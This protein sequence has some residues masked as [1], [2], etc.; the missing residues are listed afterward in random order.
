LENRTLLR[1][2]VM[3]DLKAR[4]VGS[5]M[6]FFWSVIFPLINLCVFTFVFRI[7]LKTRWSDEQG[8]LEVAL[9][10]L[11]GIIVWTAFAE[12]V[13]RCT[14]CLVDNA[15]LL[16]KVVFPA[17]VF[18]AYI[19]T[20]AI[21]NMCIGLPIVLGAVVWFGY[22]SEPTAA[23]E[24]Q[25]EYETIWEASE[26]VLDEEGRV[27]LT[28]PRV[29][30]SLERAWRMPTAFKLAYGGTATRGV[31]YLAPHDEVVL[32]AGAARLYIPVIPLR[33]TLNDEGPETIEISVTDPGGRELLPGKDAVTIT[34]QESVLPAEEIARDNGAQEA[35][36]LYKSADSARN[37]PLA[38]GLSLVMLPVLLA[39][40][41]LYTIGLSSFLAAFNLYWRDTYHL[42]GVLLTAWMFATPI[43]YPDHMVPEG[44]RWMLMVN[45]MHWFVEMFKQVTL[46]G[47][48][49]SPGYLAP[50]AVVA[51]LTFFIGMRFF[52]RH[53]PSFPD[54]L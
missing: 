26:P 11:A 28:W 48:W 51:C 18:P 29:F 50:F 34:L 2:F 1:D 37:H 4:Y 44:M 6:G 38:L 24:R 5:S 27:T 40:L 35:V 14:N 32:P 43:F 53:E 31:D 49:P 42:V 25:N 16:Q 39:L 8:A 19:T 47:I 10:M 15:N 21:L 9:V 22:L 20:S 12:S 54:L 30:V 23:L 7:I 52:K 17:S 3:R 33:D 46:F 13:S 45:P 41:G 36:G